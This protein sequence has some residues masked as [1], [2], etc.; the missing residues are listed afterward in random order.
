MHIC[1]EVVRVVLWLYLHQ[2]ITCFSYV[3]SFL[4]NPK[5]KYFFGVSFTDISC[6]F[7][8]NCFY[9]LFSVK[10]ALFLR[11]VYSRIVLYIKAVFEQY[12]STLSN[13]DSQMKYPR[14]LRRGYLICAISLSELLL[15]YVAF[16]TLYTYS[17]KQ[18]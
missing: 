15:F 8:V 6:I 5:H 9:R 13:I 17:F 12:N 16:Y 11:V 3:F 14:L 1:I 4:T 2:K 10:L 7:F 18:I